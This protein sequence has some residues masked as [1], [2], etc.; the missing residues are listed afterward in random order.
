MFLDGAL[1]PLYGL[2]GTLQ[3]LLGASDTED[4][5]SGADRSGRRL[6]NGSHAGQ[7]RH[8][9]R[10]HHH[11]HRHD[12]SSRRSSDPGVSDGSYGSGGS[13][14]SSCGSEADALHG[15]VQAA[16]NMLD[17]FQHHMGLLISRMG[18]YGSHAAVE[19]DAVVMPMQRLLAQF[20]NEAAMLEQRLTGTAAAV[21]TQR[22]SRS[23]S[24][25]S[26]GR[27]DTL[28]A[29]S[30]L[31]VAE[32][33]SVLKDFKLQ[34]AAL[35]HQLSKHQHELQ[36]LLVR[37]IDS[38]TAMADSSNV[39]QLALQGV[40]ARIQTLKARLDA[41]Q[42]QQQEVSKRS[43]PSSR[44]RRC[45]SHNAVHWSTEGATA[46]AGK[47]LDS[48]LAGTF[49]TTSLRSLSGIGSEGLSLD[50]GVGD[51]N[52]PRTQLVGVSLQTGLARGISSQPS[53]LSR[54][55][56][57]K[58]LNSMTQYLLSNPSS[59]RFSGQNLTA[60][61]QDAAKS[62][63]I[64][65]PSSQAVSRQASF[66]GKSLPS[67]SP[68][69]VSGMHPGNAFGSTIANSSL[70]DLALMS[71]RTTS[72]ATAAGTLSP[73]TSAFA[74]A[75]AGPQSDAAAS[76]VHER[77]ATL[78]Q[79]ASRLSDRAQSIFGSGGSAVA[80]ST[81][82]LPGTPGQRVGL[83]TLTSST[84]AY[85]S[86]LQPSRSLSAL[87][88]T[89]SSS[90]GGVANFK[91]TLPGGDGYSSAKVTPRPAS[92]SGTY[93]GTA[94]AGLG[95]QTSHAAATALLNRTHVSTSLGGHG[96]GVTSSGLGLTPS[97]YAARLGGSSQRV[98]AGGL[99][100]SMGSPRLSNLGL[101]VAAGLGSLGGGLDA[102]AGVSTSGDIGSR[103]KG[104]QQKWDSM[105]SQSSSLG[106]FKT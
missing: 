74:A 20:D 66:T 73:H 88:A 36:D 23:R 24:S 64:Q 15:E 34:I 57:E 86:Q 104:L 38:T 58:Q 5:G 21:A 45:K 4:G 63:H 65:I 12:D 29:Q 99:G 37:D 93:T 76:S 101:G 39:L 81:P 106:L 79:Q 68:V 103:L 84:G 28:Q 2:V 41:L 46:D 52:S 71:P 90:L 55:A 47:Q 67:V 69:A 96:A 70:P 1:G 14:G 87:G 100:L 33:S 7:H 56:S 50:G 83:G 62:L 6:H 31:H 22:N 35:T 51:S 102:P 44:H 49:G 98:T 75:A 30:L 95:S 53:G 32:V 105:N 19:L 40:G 59:P 97:S 8:G 61:G 77:L 42:Q 9:S 13:S 16:Q 43:G 25:S 94:T 91:S 60:G 92:A 18:L 11:H 80:T 85:G 26:T 48:S 3:Q 89:S 10:H 54:S 27:G 17:R 78:S 82:S 72:A